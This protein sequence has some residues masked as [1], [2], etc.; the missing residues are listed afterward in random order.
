MI[1]LLNLTPRRRSRNIN[2]LL[3]RYNSSSN[4]NTA[5][6]VVE[7]DG[8]DNGEEKA[9]RSGRSF[10]GRGSNR[11]NVDLNFSFEDWNEHMSVSRHFKHFTPGALRNSATFRRLLF[12]DLFVVGLTSS[13][14]TW[15]NIDVADDVKVKLYDVAGNMIELHNSMLTLPAIPFTLC[16]F[17]LGLLVS[18]RLQSGN[19]R[20][21]QARKDWGAIINVTRDLGSRFLTRLPDD[22]PLDKQYAVRLIQTFTVALNYHLTDDG[23]NEEIFTLPDSVRV[24]KT[25]THTHTHSLSQSIFR[26]IL[27]NNIVKIRYRKVK[28]RP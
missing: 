15:W 5:F 8:E 14:I 11:R 6:H 21:V 12:P 1:R 23:W 18:F 27:T 2:S 3:K 25:H 20:Y 4:D 10:V 7:G 26:S 17:A 16:S 9:K 28:G 19:A 22:N 24:E 13:A